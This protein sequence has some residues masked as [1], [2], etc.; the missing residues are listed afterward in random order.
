MT[1]NHNILLQ[2]RG[3][4]GG[5]DEAAVLHSCRNTNVLNAILDM[6][7]LENMLVCVRMSFLT[8]ALALPPPQLKLFLFKN[9]DSRQ[10]CDDPYVWL[11]RDVTISS[12][13]ASFSSQRSRWKSVVAAASACKTLACLWRQQWRLLWQKAGL[14]PQLHG[15]AGTST[16]DADMKSAF[17]FEKEFFEWAQASCRSLWYPAVGYCACVRMVEKA[18]ETICCMMEAP[19]LQKCIYSRIGGDCLLDVV[20]PHR[21]HVKVLQLW[22]E[23]KM[24]QFSSHLP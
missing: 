8:R 21:R 20:S 6:C 2:S 22:M 7:R 5:N 16:C 14:T 9:S 1:I 12:I 4:N 19:A 15:I 11:A 17:A 13:Q 10:L 3:L 23:V 24:L 18:L